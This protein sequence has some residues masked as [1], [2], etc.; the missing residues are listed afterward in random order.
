MR[1][2][3]SALRRNTCYRSFNNLQQCLLNTFTG[4]ITGNGYILTL[5]ADLIDFINIDNAILRTFNII[6]CCLNQFQKNILDIFADITCFRKRCRI[7]NCKRHVN[8]LGKCLCKICLT[9]T[10]G[11][12]HD[13]IAFLKLHIIGRSFR[14]HYTLIV[15]IYGHCKNFLCFFLPN[16][17]IIHEVFDFSRFK[18]IDFL[19]LCSLRF[20]FKLFLDN[21][22]TDI[23]AFITDINACRSGNQLFYLILRLI[24]KRTS[25]LS[26][27][28]SCHLHSHI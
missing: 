20:I 13:N 2:L 23:H 1:M 15:I 28:L 21:V 24:A 19:F 17:I 27:I 3:S 4:Y 25:N 8:D 10:C 14:C 16:N 6:I 12:D 26:G 5:L 7:C 18:Q 22:C 9:G 11:T